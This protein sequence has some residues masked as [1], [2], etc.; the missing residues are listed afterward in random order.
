MSTKAKR[1][2]EILF[3]LGIMGLTLYAIFY[4]QN[5]MQILGALRQMK[6][7]Y[8]LF[9]FLLGIAFVS[10]EGT[11]IWFLLHGLHGKSGLFQ[12]IGYSFI[13]FFYSGITPS[14]TGGQP[15]QLYYMQKD[16][17]RASDSTVVLMTVALIYKLVLVLVGAGILLGWSAPLHEHLGK[18]YYL[19]LIGIGL[20]TLLVL[21]IWA[22]MICPGVIRRLMQ[23]VEHLLVRLGIWKADAHRMDN[24][25][26]FIQSYQ[27]AV[28]FLRENPLKIGIVV[29]L[30]FVQRSTLFVLTYMIY[31]GFG[32]HGAAPMTVILLQA[33]VYIAV[34]MLPI[35]GAQGIT[36][37]MYQA[38][39]S[40]VFT[41][42]WL[43]PSMLVSRAENF[44]LLLIISMVIAIVSWRNGKRKKKVYAS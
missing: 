18:Y 41:G 9:A 21:L 28:D 13:G 20:N 25:E 42:G 5:P 40:G 39:F 32:L 34:D 31:L 44:Y 17:N 30:T 19:F 14:A 8:G 7:V 38:V 11:M 1:V 2:L 3:F 23:G 26:G 43:L 4:K 6:P 16:G 15:M 22:V 12:C 36:E 27:N 37:L 29:L 35:P 10:L 24:I 33:S